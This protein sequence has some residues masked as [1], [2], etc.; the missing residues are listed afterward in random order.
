MNNR[1]FIILSVLTLVT[2]I[3]WTVF[4]IV[5]TT[6]KSTITPVVQTQIK[7]IAPNFDMKTLKDLKSRQ[8][9]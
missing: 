3:L 4:E 1:D 6:Q 7:P 5:H 8:N 2:V 9:Q